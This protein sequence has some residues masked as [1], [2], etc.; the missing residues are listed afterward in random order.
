MPVSGRVLAAQASGRVLPVSGRVLEAQASG[1]VLAVSGRVLA[2]QARYPLY[3][4]QLLSFCLCSILSHNISI[5]LH[6]SN[7]RLF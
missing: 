2:A 1:K 6:V 4:W 5:S 3:S 7:V